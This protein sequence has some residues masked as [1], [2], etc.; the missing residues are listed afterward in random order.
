MSWDEKNFEFLY[1]NR[2][3]YITL[4]WLNTAKKCVPLYAI[5]LFFY[6]AILLFQRV[7]FCV[8]LFSD[9]NVSSVL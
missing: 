7:T 4:V 5:L 3:E 2:H 6:P 8:L 1:T 9:K